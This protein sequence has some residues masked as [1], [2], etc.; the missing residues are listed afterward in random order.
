MAKRPKRWRRHARPPQTRSDRPRQHLPERT[1]PVARPQADRRTASGP[2]APQE[3]VTYNVLRT[4]GPVSREPAG[5]R[6]APAGHGA[7]TVALSATSAARA[8]RIRSTRPG[9]PPGSPPGPR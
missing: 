4:L 7:V 9:S 6:A 8:A 2:L 5:G 1:V 3:I